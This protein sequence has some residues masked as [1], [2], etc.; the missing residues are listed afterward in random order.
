MALQRG[1][2]PPSIP[3][4]S[5]SHVAPPFPVAIEALLTCNPLSAVIGRAPFR[6]HDGKR[7]LDM[8]ETVSQISDA[9]FEALETQNM[10]DGEAVITIVPGKSDMLT[11]LMA[12]TQAAKA[13][14]K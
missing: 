8:G 3:L 9:L 14:S 7:S 11:Q 2:R 4:A 5:Q 12:A 10:I 1:V 13:S 6:V